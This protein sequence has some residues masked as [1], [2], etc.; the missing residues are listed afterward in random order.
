MYVRGNIWRRMLST[1][2]IDTVFSFKIIEEPYVELKM[3]MDKHLKA[4]G[5]SG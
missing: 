1:I 2:F 5:C 4:A 3:K